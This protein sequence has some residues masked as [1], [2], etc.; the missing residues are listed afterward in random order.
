MDTEISKRIKIE[1][2]WKA[3]LLDEFDQENITL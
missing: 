2:S 1:S 3:V